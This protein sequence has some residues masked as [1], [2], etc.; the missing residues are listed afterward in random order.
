MPRLWTDTIEAHRR[1]VRD[2]IIDATAELADRHGM[3]AVTMSQIAEAA[4][5]GRATLYK[6]FPDVQSIVVAWHE[7]SIRS[8]LNELNRVREQARDPWSGLRGVLEAYAL[9]DFEHHGR[10]GWSRSRGRQ[11]AH[12]GRE[13]DAGVVESLHQSRHTAQ[14]EDELRSMLAGLISNAAGTGRVRADVPPNELATYCQNALRAASSMPSV[15]AVRR[16]VT[17]TLAGLA[18]SP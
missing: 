11:S 17:V 1:D 10:T 12:H 8:H 15:A 16:L 2:A 14:A 6:Y 13:A 5:I 4:G 3:L 18:P 7:R 9:I